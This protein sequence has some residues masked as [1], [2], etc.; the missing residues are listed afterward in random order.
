MRI[1]NTHQVSRN[2]WI[3]KGF[4]VPQQSSIS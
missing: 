2:K 4:G 1:I 3:G